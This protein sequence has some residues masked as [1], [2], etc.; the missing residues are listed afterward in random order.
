MT[1]LLAYIALL[2]PSYEVRETVYRTASVYSDSLI[3]NTTKYGEIYDPT[4]HGVATRE[5]PYGTWLRLTFEGNVVFVRVTDIN[6]ERFRGKWIDLYRD[7][8]LKLGEKPYGLHHGVK[9]EVI[10]WVN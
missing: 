6:A 4:E 9:V 8:W 10:E 1:T 5:W 7:P 3:G 2:L